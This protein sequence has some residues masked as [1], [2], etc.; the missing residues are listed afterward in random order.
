MVDAGAVLEVQGE[1][2]RLL[3]RLLL[4]GLQHL[5]R[6]APRQ[7]PRPQPL[8]SEAQPRGRSHLRRRRTHVNRRMPSVVP[9]AL[10][11]ASPVA[12]K[13]PGG[14]QGRL[15][16]RGHAL[17]AH[18]GLGRRRVEGTR[19]RVRHRLDRGR[20]CAQAGGAPH[21]AREP[22]G[23][24]RLHHLRRWGR[25]HLGGRAQR[26]GRGRPVRVHGPIAHSEGD[27]DRG[28]LPWGPLAQE[29]LRAPQAEGR[30]RGA[31]P[32]PLA[33]RRGAHAAAHA[34]ARAAAHAHACTSAA[35]AVA[36][37]A[38]THLRACGC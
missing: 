8:L 13:C 18:Q 12:P 26:V 30:R 6:D 24:H 15:A 7:R 25:H 29:G 23:A 1:I 2:P 10:E 16:G 5:R 20:P 28:H 14:V 11:R 19:A 36:S 9:A 4:C 32:W 31:R 37:G 22:H 17:P 27:H 33:L 38:T 34:R 35:G 21:G 3:C